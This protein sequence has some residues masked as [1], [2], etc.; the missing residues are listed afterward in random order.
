[1]LWLA[2]S[3][4][5]TQDRLF[6]DAL[7]AIDVVG[8]SALRLLL[9]SE[10]QD[11]FGVTNPSLISLLVKM[12]SNALAGSMPSLL[13]SAC[14]AA[15]SYLTSLNASA[16]RLLLNKFGDDHSICTVILF[17]LG[18]STCCRHTISSFSADCSRCSWR[19]RPDFSFERG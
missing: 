13:S 19:T 8:D 15:A 5:C 17:A 4:V 9:S 7:S 2:A 12:H 11:N 14:A 3:L 10:S 16:Y 6:C 1:V 18:K